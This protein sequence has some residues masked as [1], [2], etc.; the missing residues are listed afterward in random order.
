MGANPKATNHENESFEL[1]VDLGAVFQL[2]ASRYDTLLLAHKEAVQNSLDEGATAISIVLNKKTRY[3][4]LRDNGKGVSSADFGGKLMNFCR[5]LKGRG[6]IGRHGMGFAAF[7]GKCDYFTFTTCPRAGK[8]PYRKYPFVTK[9]IFSAAKKPTIDSEVVERYVYSPMGTAS[10][11]GKEGVW[12]RSQVEVFNF[13][14]DKV[15]G[16]IESI[17]DLEQVIMREF[18]IRLL[19]QKVVLNIKFTDE[20]GKL[21]KKENIR[22]EPWTGEPLETVVIRNKKVGSAVFELFRTHKIAGGGKSEVSVGEIGNDTR[23]EFGRWAREQGGVPAD[24]VEALTSGELEGQ[25]T[26]RNVRLETGGS[27]RHFDRNEALEGFIEA[28][29]EWYR[30][31]GE[32][33][34]EGFREEK[35]E[36][37]WREIF[38]RS[39][40]NFA[41]NLDANPAYRDWKD[42]FKFNQKPDEQAPESGVVTSDP[43][44]EKG[45]G[46]R[47]GG[48][49]GSD[50]SESKPKRK[51]VHRAVSKAGA[52]GLRLS[53]EPTEEMLQSNLP[54]HLDVENGLLRFNTRHP[55]WVA[56]DERSAVSLQ[57]YQELALHCAVTEFVQPEVDKH[58]VRRA[59]SDLLTPLVTGCFHSSDA[60]VISHRRKD[61]SS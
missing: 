39:L 43:R 44:P 12:W 21:T 30:E 13:T 59:L 45:E 17:E 35:R 15:V 5:T 24:I 3:Y 40:D 56:C 18:K 25:I 20:N 27:R 31:Y 16:R 33:L 57:Q 38:E 1:G 29:Q 8:E 34:L 10:P 6:D 42:L 28:L 36:E 2:L 11:K 54:Y 52:F 60:F 41:K 50:T 55:V 32:P 22:A 9:E 7:M 51:K 37:R 47:E 14:S 46:T 19:R 58:A 23:I 4:A 49:G 53:T 61:R 26:G 48:G